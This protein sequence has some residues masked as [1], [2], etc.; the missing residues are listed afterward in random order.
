MRFSFIQTH[1]LGLWISFHNIFTDSYKCLCVWY[2]K[3]H[4]FMFIQ[5]Y[6]NTMTG[7]WF[8]AFLCTTTQK[9]S[10]DSFGEPPSLLTFTKK[11][12]AR[13]HTHTYMYTYNIHI[14]RVNSEKQ[15]NC[16]FYFL[17]YMRKSKRK[18]RIQTL[19]L[20]PFKRGDNYK[21]SLSC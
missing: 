16:L 10:G 2:V 14:T 13:A 6:L 12:L 8:P 20:I 17:V 3:L 18:K 1:C 21:L 9:Q 5:I 19:D 11:M 4:I 15:R 7:I